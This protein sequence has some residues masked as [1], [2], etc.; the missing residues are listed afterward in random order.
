MAEKC[1]FLT[2]FRAFPA[3]FGDTAVSNPTPAKLAVLGDSR[4]ERQS[5]SDEPQLT[6][7]M[8]FS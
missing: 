2:I 5:P 3:F 4:S 6:I 8:G 7:P 1:P